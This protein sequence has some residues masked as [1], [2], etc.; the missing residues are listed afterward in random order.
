MNSKYLHLALEALFP[1]QCRL[2]HLPSGSAVP[3]CDHCSQALVRNTTPCLRCA[4]PLNG[5]SP[6]YCPAC[7]ESPPPFTSITAPYLYEPCLAYLVHQWKYQGERQFAALFARLWLEAIT[8]LPA[9]DL[10]VTVPLHW[11]RLLRRGFNQ[12]ELLLGEIRR[13]CPRLA[14]IDAD[15]R[16]VHKRL[17]TTHQVGQT[18]WQRQRN[19][20][21]AFT[22]Q[23]RCDNLRVAVIEDVV[24]TGATAVAISGALANAGAAEV[25]IWCLART[26]PPEY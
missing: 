21:G 4:L 3:L 18:A 16:R 12:T 1:Q 9:V 5:D 13:A 23:H 26:P 17:A 19:L 14:T 8:N 10:M 25:H 24:T 11:S 6:G 15:P 7:L 2:C 20:A 22:V